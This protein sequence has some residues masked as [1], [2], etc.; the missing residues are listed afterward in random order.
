MLPG[1]LRFDDSIEV[2]EEIVVITTK[3]EAICVAY[4]QMTS[5]QVTFEKVLMLSHFSLQ[6]KS[7]AFFVLKKTKKKLV[8]NPL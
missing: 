6:K 1:V 4:A 7:F 3:G 8:N 2:G 5:M